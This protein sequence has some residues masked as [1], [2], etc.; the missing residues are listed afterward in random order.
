MTVVKT[1][2]NEEIGTK[3][4]IVKYEDGRYGY[5]YYEFFQSI[6]WKFMWHEDCRCS[7]EFIEEE[8][9]IKVA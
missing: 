2:I 3:Y 6:G 4:E 7:K 1:I 9:E 5:R 8:F